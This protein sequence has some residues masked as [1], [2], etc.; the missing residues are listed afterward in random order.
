MQL[1]GKGTPVANC[2]GGHTGHQF[3]EGVRLQAQACRDR[4]ETRRSREGGGGERL[5]PILAWEWGLG[6][7]HNFTL[8]SIDEGVSREKV[9]QV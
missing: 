8:E 3:A 9:L 4:Q 2:L 7:A 5:T 1:G 6:E